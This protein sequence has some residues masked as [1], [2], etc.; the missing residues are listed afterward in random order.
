V[1]SPRRIG[2]PEAMRMRHDP[3]FVDQLVR[4]SGETI[5]RLIP[6]EDIAPNPDQPRQA[7]GDL[8]E[9]TASIREKGVLEPLLVRRV[10]TQFQIIAGERRYRAAL[11]AGLGELPCVVRETS[12][13]EMMELALIENMQRKDLTPFEEGDGLSVLVDKYGYTHEAMA[14]KIGK[15][16]T[17]ITESLSLSAMPEEVRQQCRRAD[18]QSKSMLLQ[19]V[20]Q[21]DKDKMLAL[22]ERLRR[23][24]G[25]TRGDARRFAQKSEGRR[26][27]GRPRHYVFQYKPRGGPF[28]LALQ[29]KRAD[30]ERDEIIEALEA[31]LRSLRDEA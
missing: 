15:S 3:H 25:A 19:V 4:P 13:A 1:S 31:V 22:V 10:G 11:E 20:R 17:T 7:L 26:G 27:R 5:G 23:E 30:V 14:E 24:G 16:R 6:I 18:I 2:L 9:L 21:G 28:S 8:D 12:D 29:F